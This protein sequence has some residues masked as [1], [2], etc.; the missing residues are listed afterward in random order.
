[1]IDNLQ[2][3]YTE[4]V[5][6]R[7]LVNQIKIQ[8]PKLGIDLGVGGGSLTKALRN[9]WKKIKIE[10]F[11]LDKNAYRCENDKKIIFEE[12]DLLSLKSFKQFCLNEKKYE[13]AVCNPPY[14]DLKMK[15]HHKKL[16]RMMNFH[17][18]EKMATITSDVYFLLKNLHNLKENGI[19][20]IVM[21]DSMV[22]SF[23][24][25]KFRMDL[26]EKF[27]LI[28][29]YQLP[30]N[31][32]N[33]TE[34]QAYILILKK[35]VPLNKDT[36]IGLLNPK[37]KIIKK[38]KISTKELIDRADPRFHLESK[39]SKYSEYKNIREIGGLILRGNTSNTVAKRSNIK[40]FH[41]TSFKEYGDSISFKK[42]R[43]VIS[44]IRAQAGDI[45][46]ARV[47]SRCV[48]RVAT[49]ISGEQIISDCI[50][51]IRVPLRFRARLLKSLS[52]LEG[53]AWIN[54]RTKGTCARLISM[55]DLYD[56]PLMS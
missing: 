14:K 6:A 7:F 27:Q 16:L 17:H 10:T 54:S 46:M 55:K 24:F 37:A 8:N 35:A 39:I 56:F 12:C 51:V 34:A 33:S 11:D 2:R 20:G 42:N 19:L 47:G 9:R 1:M 38:K 26:F 23:K 41:T 40:I 53:R 31:A 18:T 32:F 44:G 49:V 30:I 36:V 52:S 29:C 13:V 4:D 5:F 48:G 50:F 25:K 3:H 21:P 45:L 22:S 15:N 28:A 43:T